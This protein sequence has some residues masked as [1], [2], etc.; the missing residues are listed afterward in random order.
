MII[1]DDIHFISLYLQVQTHRIFYNF[2][3]ILFSKCPGRCSWSYRDCSINFNVRNWLV[4]YISFTS[5]ILFLLIQNTLTCLCYSYMFL[6]C[7]LFT[8]PGEEAFLWKEI[9]KRLDKKLED[10]E[11]IEINKKSA[12]LN[13][14]KM[15]SEKKTVSTNSL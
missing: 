8:A 10:N 12:L 5:S 6:T 3:S 15:D 11:E 14:S 13:D 1:W 2:I 4:L 9:K 7:L